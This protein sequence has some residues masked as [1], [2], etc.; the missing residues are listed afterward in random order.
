MNGAW[1]PLFN[2]DHYS[3][4]LKILEAIYTVCFPSLDLKLIQWPCSTGHVVS[5]LE[6]DELFHG[7]EDQLRELNSLSMTSWTDSQPILRANLP[8]NGAEYLV[9][10][11]EVLCPALAYIGDLS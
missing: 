4:N 9:E 7:K 8:S 10:R 6:W 1:L 5:P 11:I 3:G 2:C